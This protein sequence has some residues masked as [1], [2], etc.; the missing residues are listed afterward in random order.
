MRKAKL[1]KEV[2]PV[3]LFFSLLLSW[4]LTT[5]GSP[6]QPRSSPPWLSEILSPK[7]A[8]Q[9]PS[10]LTRACLRQPEKMADS[11]FSPRAPRHLESTQPSRKLF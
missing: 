8:C 9:L 10:R 5:Q 6:T 4:E 11:P 2:Y 7:P 1:L 3:L